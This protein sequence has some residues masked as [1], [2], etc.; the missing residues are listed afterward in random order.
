MS[1]TQFRLRPLR[2]KNPDGTIV[3]PADRTMVVAEWSSK[4]GSIAANV[5]PA[6]L[7]YRN[8]ITGPTLWTVV[9]IVGE[10]APT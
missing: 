6:V 4:Y 7:E 5:F 3:A 8:P 2:W 9:K 1:G 10:D